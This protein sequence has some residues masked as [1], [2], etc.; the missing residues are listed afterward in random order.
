MVLIK[1]IRTYIFWG[2]TTLIFM[3]VCIL[4]SF[5]PEKIR[6]NRFYYFM[7]TIWDKLL[8]FFTF[9]LVDVE[10]KENLPKF[11]SEP[12]IIVMNHIS[13]LDIPLIEDLIGTYPHIWVSKA[14]YTKVPFWGILIKRI[15]VPVQRDNP[16]K[17]IQALLRAYNIVKDK[18][19]HILIF[20]EGTRS[21]DGKLQKFLGGFGV[22]AKK[23]N[24]PVIPVAISGSNKVMPKK[25]LMVSPRASDIN[26]IIGDKFFI[27]E[28]E[29][30]KE[31]VE[32]VRNWFEQKIV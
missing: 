14:S 22:L 6:R 16:R 29:G 30:E 20:P 15:H 24:R 12:A 11:P 1:T 19:I 26:M 4:L 10:G 31:F 3:P 7:T 28:E 8:V 5:L 25:S 13:S 17:A 23:L 27:G 9:T 21:Q 2:A 32:R 18:D